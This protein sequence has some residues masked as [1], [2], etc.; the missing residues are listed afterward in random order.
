MDRKREQMLA[1][2]KGSKMADMRVVLMAAMMAEKSECAKAM[3][4]DCSTVS[5]TVAQKALLLVCC[6]AKTLVDKLVE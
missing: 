2:W 6:S 3:T 4:M 1:G 5:M